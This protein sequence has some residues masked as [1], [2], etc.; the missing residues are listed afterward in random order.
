MLGGYADAV[1]RK[2]LDRQNKL[3]TRL[4]P[5]GRQLNSQDETTLNANCVILAWFEEVYRSRL[6]S[7]G[8][9]ILLRL[10][11][12]KG[13]ISGVQSDMV[14]DISQLSSAF[15]VDAKGLFKFKSDPILNPTFEGSTDVGGADAD[16]IVDKALMEFKCTSKLDAPK[17]RDAALQLLGYML[18]DY[19][20]EY[21]VSDLLVYLPRQRFFWRIPLW[22]L[23]LAPEAVQEI[24]KRGDTPKTEEVSEQLRKRRLEFRTVA[25][26]RK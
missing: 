7:P 1:G 25:K 21:D 2:F 14:Q 12:V 20:G 15:A 8:L 26:S 6:V 13:L 4:S 19:D 17:L 5:V 23:V 10:A 16:M 9:D 3:V 24:L 18:L 22:K 11:N